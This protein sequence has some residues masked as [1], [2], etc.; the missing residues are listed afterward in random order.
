MKEEMVLQN[1]KVPDNECLYNE[2]RDTCSF[3]AFAGPKGKGNIIKKTSQSSVDTSPP[4]CDT[5]G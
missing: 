2:S 3:T 1:L 5:K 4:A